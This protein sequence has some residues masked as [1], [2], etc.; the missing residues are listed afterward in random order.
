VL[1]VLAPS[2]CGERGN[3]FER[4]LRAGR[5]FVLERGSGW[6]SGSTLAPKRACVELGKAREQ[7]SRRTPAGTLVR[8]TAGGAPPLLGADELLFRRSEV[9][10]TRSV[11]QRYPDS[12][13]RL[14]SRSCVPTLSHKRE[15]DGCFAGYT[16]QANRLL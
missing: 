7:R 11:F 4:R 9:L 6:S 16:H 15:T 5:E 14:Q 2:R 13:T 3:V 12:G 1:R 10:P 8:S